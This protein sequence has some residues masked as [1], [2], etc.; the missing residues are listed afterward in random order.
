MKNSV[1]QYTLNPFLGECFIISINLD[2][3][4]MAELKQC[5]GLQIQKQHHKF[6][7]AMLILYLDTKTAYW[8]PAV[9]KIR[10]VDN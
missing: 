7:L 6:P 9:L 1:T 5:V 10:N 8:I 2:I 3:Q 4:Y